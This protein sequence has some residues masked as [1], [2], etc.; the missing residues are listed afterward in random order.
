[1]SSQLEQINYPIVAKTHPPMYS[2]HKFWARK[3]H[4]VVAKY[5]EKYSKKNDIVFDPFCGSGVTVMEALR[6]GRKAIGI[7]LDPLATFVTRCSIICIDTTEFEKVFE[8]I[9]EKTYSR[10]DKLYE[11]VCSKCGGK[12]ELYGVA[13]ENDKPFEKVVN[14]PKCGRIRGK[15]AQFDLEK[16]AETEKMNIEFWYPK[17]AKLPPLKREKLQFVYE[18]FTKRNLIALSAIFNEIEELQEGNLKEIMKFVFSSTLAQ[19]T[20]MMPYVHETI[21]KICKGWTTHSYWVPP[22]HWELNVF[23]YLKSRFNEIKR[24]KEQSNK[25]FSGKKEAKKLSELLKDA[26][27]Y[28]KTCSALE[29]VDENFPSKNIVDTNSVDYIFTDPPYGGSIQYLELSVLSTSWLKLPIH[30]EDEI[31]INKYQQKGFER[32]DRMLRQAFRQTYKTL[33]PNKYMT[34]T[35][36]N[37]KIRIRNSLIKAVVFAGFDMEK[38][39]YQP[40]AVVSAKASRQPYGSAIGDYYIRFKK[41]IQEKLKTEAK[42]DEERYE[43]VVVETVKRILAERGEPTSY[44]YLLNFVDVELER[45]GLLLGARTEIKDVLNKHKGK[46][47]ILVETQDGLIKGSKWWFKDPSAV[48]F[49]DRIPL[50][51]RV[52]RAIINVLKGK[53]KVTFDD[54]LQ[55]IYI[56]FPNALTP[57]SSSIMTYLEAYAIKTDGK[58]RLSPTF[59][60]EEELHIE[61]IKHLAQMGIKFGFKVWSAH[62]DEELLK[63]TE[64]QL[65]LPIERL[66][67][68]E[69]IDV[70][71]IRDD[72]IEYEFEVENTTQVTEAIVRGSNIPYKT[73]RIILIPERREKMLKRKFEEPLIKEIVEKDS[74][75]MITYED[76]NT[77]I[78]KSR[79]REEISDFVKIITFPR[80]KEET[81]R[82]ILDY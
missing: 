60:M 49:L 36:H 48:P 19:A 25:F 75:R 64:G 82:S 5:I 69:K 13:W 37:T 44:S 38:I 15:I 40:P 52:E 51:E 58:W 10:Y 18:L 6:L 72:K 66:D 29:L 73:N 23:H 4:N 53:D 47:F 28:L 21:G 74:W 70:L 68:I 8:K 50:N 59:K 31:T 81:Q 7:D 22:Q 57:E 67:R 65:S 61:M 76:L 46:E 16:I 1:M 20:K 39:V 43:R 30:F 24:G 78:Q 3:P 42:I 9:F 56:K 33:K 17:D 80:S 26:D 55:E 34:V 14:C 35:F 71:W 63:I 45:N 41:P 79:K 62:K 12:A 77:Y 27:Y 2:M 54:V 32:Y 11:T